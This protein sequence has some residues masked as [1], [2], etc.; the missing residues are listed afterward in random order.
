[1]FRFAAK[2]ADCERE[3]LERH[4]FFGFVERSRNEA[5]KRYSGKPD[6]IVGWIVGREGHALR[7]SSGQAQM[8][9]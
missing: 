3:G 9:K 1:M 7:L 4:P 6:P 8:I 2:F 5:E